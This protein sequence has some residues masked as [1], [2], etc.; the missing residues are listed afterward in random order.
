[1]IGQQATGQ[2]SAAG[3][4]KTIRAYANWSCSLLVRLKIYGVRK[5][6]RVESSHGRKVTNCNPVRAINQVPVRYGSMRSQAE[7][8]SPADIVRKESPQM[9]GKTGYPVQVAKTGACTELKA[10]KPFTNSQVPDA[11]M[12]FHLQLVWKDPGKTNFRRA[13]N[14]IAINIFQQYSPQTPG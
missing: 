13:V 11:R 5:N 6:L 7:L 4:H 2:D 1:M 12:L 8:R 10:A 9:P 3:A 14:A